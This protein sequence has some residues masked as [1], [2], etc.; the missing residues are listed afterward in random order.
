MR[1]VIMECMIPSSPSSRFPQRGVTLSIVSMMPPSEAPCELRRTP[2]WRSS[3]VPR[4]G[5]PTSGGTI[6][7]LVGII[8]VL[9][10]TGYVPPILY[11][12]RPA[13]LGAA[14]PSDLAVLQNSREVHTLRL[15]TARNRSTL[16]VWLKCCQLATK[17]RI[18]PSR[19]PNLPNQLG[20]F[21]TANFREF[22][23]H[24]LR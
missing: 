14:E 24:A 11:I 10:S 12:R 9:C 16:R 7:R 20:R 8:W 2:F 3:V 17:R 15:A 19:S 1:H 21:A 18:T 13:R 22:L 6:I 4:P 23:F 5:A